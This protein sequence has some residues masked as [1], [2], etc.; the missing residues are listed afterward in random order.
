MAAIYSTLFAELELPVATQQ[1]LFTV[2]AGQVMIVRDIDVYSN[3]T[4]PCNIGFSGTGAAVIFAFFNF[5]A[6]FTSLQWQGRQVFPAGSQLNGRASSAAMWC[7][8]SGYLLT[9]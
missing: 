6:A 5:T 1:L 9:V 4:P 7:R 8:V 3:A 2:P